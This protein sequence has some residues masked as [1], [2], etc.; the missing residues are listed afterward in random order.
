M[1]R[2]INRPTRSVSG[3]TAEGRKLGLRA[4]AE[5]RRRLGA[6]KQQEALLRAANAAASTERPAYEADIPIELL[7]VKKFQRKIRPGWVLRLAMGW[8]SVQAGHLRVSA[9]A[10]GT[11]SI[12]DGQQRWN[13]MKSLNDVRPGTFAKVPCVVYR[14][15]T[16]EEEASLFVS[17]NTETAKP[18]PMEIFVGR[19]EA[20]DPQSVAIERIILGNGFHIGDSL[21][22]SGALSSVM[23]LEDIYASWGE[24]VLDTTFKVMKTAFPDSPANTRSRDMIMAISSWLQCY[25][26]QHVDSIRLIHVL[27]EAPLHSL[28]ADA[29]VSYAAK[30][31]SVWQHL[32]ATF[33]ILYNKRLHNRLPDY[34]MP[35]HKGTKKYSPKALYE[36]AAAHADE[37][38]AAAVAED[39]AAAMASGRSQE[40]FA[41]ARS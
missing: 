38:V 39:V 22:V 6:Q 35:Q 41:V 33:T 40:A 21:K 5:T 18:S 31:G 26:D 3:L 37:T 34:V 14:G 8:D 24:K 2:K 36:V 25:R 4:S 23:S 28:Y 11:F 29:K 1:T 17:W 32:A 7:Q 12:L 20:K 10:D 9:Q 19:I 13:A 30:G 16:Y 27:T 15:L